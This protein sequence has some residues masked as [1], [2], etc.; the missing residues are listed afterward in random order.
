MTL[1]PE[2]DKLI[3]LARSARARTGAQHGAAVRDQDGRTYAASTVVLPSLRFD[4]LDLA[5][6]M[7][8][9]RRAAGRDGQRLEQQRAGRRVVAVDLQDGLLEVE[10]EVLGAGRREGERAADAAAVAVE[11][12]AAACREQTDG[13]LLLD[14]GGHFLG[15][16]V[17]MN[18]DLRWTVDGERAIHRRSPVRRQRISSGK[19]KH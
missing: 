16:E 10:G 19:Q 4:A 9:V 14:V 11:G 13:R 5:V 2:D 7:A 17:Q 1:S 6:A 12:V 3:T 18:E 8:G 15:I